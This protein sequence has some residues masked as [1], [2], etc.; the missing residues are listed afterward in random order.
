MTS[1]SESSGVFR[2]PF[3]RVDELE[4]RVASVEHRLSGI[5]GKLSRVEAILWFAASLGLLD[6]IKPFLPIIGG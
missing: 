1:F 3:D 5:E 6:Q 2:V 4:R